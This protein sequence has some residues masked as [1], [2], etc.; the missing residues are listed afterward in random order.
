MAIDIERRIEDVDGLVTLLAQQNNV[1]KRSEYDFDDDRC[2]A[3]VK[4]EGEANTVYFRHEKDAIA[5]Y[6]SPD[7]LVISAADY[8]RRIF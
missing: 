7:R 1:S 5:V 3:N 8:N 2:G 4:T 6:R